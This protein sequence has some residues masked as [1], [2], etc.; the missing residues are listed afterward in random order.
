MLL[1]IL[2]YSL[3]KPSGPGNLPFSRVTMTD[4]G[5]CKWGSLVFEFEHLKGIEDS[6]PVKPCVYFL[7]LVGWLKS[8]YVGYTVHYSN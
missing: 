2:K 4:L 8:P 7:L 3:E 5:H 1:N 6:V